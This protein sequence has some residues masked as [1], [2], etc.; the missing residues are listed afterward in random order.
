[1]SD[2]LAGLRARIEELETQAAFQEELHR[3]LDDTVAK[4][5]RELLELKR[6]LKALAQRLEEVRESGPGGGYSAA[7]QVPPHY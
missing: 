6:Q 7:D 4:Q 3:R 2:E 5:D 1:M